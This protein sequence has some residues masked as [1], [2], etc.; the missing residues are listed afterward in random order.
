[1]LVK[2]LGGKVLWK[3]E[4]YIARNSLIGDSTFFDAREFP[5]SSELEANWKTIRRELD[6]SGETPQFSGHLKGPGSHN[7]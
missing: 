7:Q 2:N 1:M 5:W 6:V 3:F 4:Q